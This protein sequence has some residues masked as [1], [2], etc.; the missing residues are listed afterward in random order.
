M[1]LAQAAIESGWGRSRFAREAHNLFGVVTDSQRQGMKP[2]KRD[3]GKKTLLRRYP[4]LRESVRGYLHT[5]N[6]HGAYRLLRETR[7]R[8]RAANQPIKG[9]ALTTG[10]K[11]YSE[12]GERYI[13]MVNALIKQNELEGLNTVELTAN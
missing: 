6:T 10:L 3:A 8:L 1:A 11:R 5:L 2:R 13:R 9:T 7:H 4:S 12:L